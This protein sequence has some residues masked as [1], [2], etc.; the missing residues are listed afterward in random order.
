LG[1]RDQTGSYELCRSSLGGYEHVKL[2]FADFFAGIGLAELGLR[3]AGWKCV[4]ANDIDK[5]KHEMWK[6]HFKRGPYVRCDIHDLRADSIPEATL[7][8]ASFPCTDVSLAGYRAG[9][10][11]S[12]SGAIFGLLRLLREKDGQRPPL[13]VL[14]NVTGFVSSHKGADFEETIRQLNGIGYACDAFLLDAIHFV[15]QSR[16]RLFIV[17]VYDEPPSRTVQ[18]ALNARPAALKS[19][20]L[21]S[22]MAT[23]DDL[24]WTILDIPAPPTTRRPL[25][26]L[27]ERLDDAS[28][29][30]WAHERVQYLLDQMSPKHREVIEDLQSKPGLNYATAYRRMRKAKSMAEVRADGIAGCLRTPRGG[31]SRQILIACGNGKVRVRFMTPREY[32]RLMGARKFTIEVAD[33]QAYFGFGDA[34]CV[35][36]VKWIAENVLNPLACSQ[37]H[38]RP[39]N[40]KADVV[41]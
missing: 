19:E 40:V 38:G 23:H 29:Y 13:V 34:V 7:W 17:G 6:E 36:V 11:G 22:F 28:H 12:Q 14:E 41:L 4:F 24:E 21:T 15:P 5:K 25:S 1:K 26:K 37:D 8:W 27:V 32:A 9:L 39:Q 30:W 16:P 35:E 2:T 20:Q 33:N 10:A 18:Y 3:V 31:S